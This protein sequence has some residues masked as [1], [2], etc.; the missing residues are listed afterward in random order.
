MCLKLKGKS[1][2]VSSWLL[3]GHWPREGSTGSS[4]ERR[5][6]DGH[7]NMRC[8]KEQREV[9]ARKGEERTWTDEKRKLHVFQTCS[10][11]F[12]A[13]LSTKLVVPN[14]QTKTVTSDQI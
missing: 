13:G 3:L 4:S 14:P 10:G 5:A 1:L 12:Q 7:R 11:G 9:G 6:G 2:T 8:G